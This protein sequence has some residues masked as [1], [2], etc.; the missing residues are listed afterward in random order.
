M[1]EKTGNMGRRVPRV[2]R[3]EDYKQPDD[4]THG[5]AEGDRRAVQRM[6]GPMMPFDNYLGPPE[7]QKHTRGASGG[8]RDR[9]VQSCV[10]ENFRDTHTVLIYHEIEKDLFRVN[11]RNR[12]KGS[13]S[14]QLRRLLMDLHGRTGSR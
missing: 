8:V 7:D 14:K 3:G 13:T 10:T 4:L 2:L 1:T 12:L 11:C 6:R 9:D 5:G